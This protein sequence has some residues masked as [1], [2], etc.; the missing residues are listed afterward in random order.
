V[1]LSFGSVSCQATTNVNGVASCTVTVVD[2]PGSYTVTASFAG[3]VTYLASSGTGTI[4]VAGKVSTRLVDNTTGNFLQGS[5]TTLS[6]TLT[7]SAGAPLAGK[8]IYLTLGLSACHG[9]TNASGVA[10]C[11]VTVPGPTGPTVSTATFLGDTGANPALDAKPALVYAFAGS[12][13]F[14]VGDRSATGSVT[15]WG[16]QWAKSNSLSGGAADNSFKGFA[17]SPATPQCGGT[18]TTDPGNSAPPPRGPLPAY[19]A[20]AVTSKTA[21]SGKTISGNVVHVVIVKTNPG[22]DANPGH[23]GTGTVVA[24]VC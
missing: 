3:D 22:Y 14:V 9:L 16:S 4:T 23:P 20:V 19:M 21:K 17:V 12:G 15:F 5:T 24:T 1:T 7:T 8:T 2:V 6:A 11:T 13:S 18:W 10:S